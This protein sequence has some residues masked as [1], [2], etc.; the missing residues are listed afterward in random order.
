MRINR[1]AVLSLL[2]LSLLATVPVWA[3]EEVCPG[4]QNLT[5]ATSPSTEVGVP[6]PLDLSRYCYWEGDCR[7]CEVTGPTMICIE[8]IC[9]TGDSQDCWPI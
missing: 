7:I 3:G 1:I 2:V 6:E 4:L 5:P 8:R 9:P